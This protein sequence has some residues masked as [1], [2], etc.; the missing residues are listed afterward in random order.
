MLAAIGA[1]EAYEEALARLVA[2]QR[3]VV[4]PR[5]DLLPVQGQDQRALTQTRVGAVEGPPS[6]DFVHDEACAL[7]RRGEEEPQLGSGEGRGRRAVASA[8]MGDVQ[9]AQQLS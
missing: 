9:L 2:Q 6:D 7:T 1:A 8:R 3:I 4:H 5:L